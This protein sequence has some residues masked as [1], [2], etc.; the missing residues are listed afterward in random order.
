MV[1][2]LLGRLPD[3]ND[4]F[5]ISDI[6]FLGVIWNNFKNLLDGPLD[7]LFLNSFITVSKSSLFVGDI[8]KELVF[9][10]I[11]YLLYLCFE[12]TNFSSICFTIEVKFLLNSSQMAF[13]TA[14]FQFG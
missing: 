14:F 3:E 8:K 11:R 7:L 4:K 1:F 5:A 6:N 10:F 12:F 9:G 2:K 13:L